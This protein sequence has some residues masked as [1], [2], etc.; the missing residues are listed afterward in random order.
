MSNDSE[1][2]YFA[3]G[4]AEDLI[5]DLSKLSGLFVIARNSTFTYKGSAI[6]VDEVA[7]ELGVRFV[8]E[9]SVRRAGDEVRIN[10]QLI[11]AVTNGHVWTERYD[12]VLNDIFALQDGVTRK[13]VAALSVNVNAGSRTPIETS[14]SKAYDIFLRG[15]N[16]HRK[17]TAREY[18]KAVPLLEQTLFSS[19]F[20]SGDGIL[21]KTGSESISS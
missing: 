6:K 9:G 17:G 20:S 14:D 21:K 12:G 5:T 16:H 11:D 18:A 8:L 10:V 13:I 2:E 7:R 1:Q 19:G 4:I 3:D 15:W